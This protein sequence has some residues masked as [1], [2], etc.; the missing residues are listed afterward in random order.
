MDSFQFAA[1][2]VEI[3]GPLR[4]SGE[5]DGIELDAQ[6]FCRDGLTDL[7]VGN[8]FHSLGGHLFEALR[9]RGHSAPPASTM[10]SNS[11]RSSSAAMVLPTS[12]LVTNSTPSADICSR[13]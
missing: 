4:T 10:A 1:G 12:A 13:R 11:M 2:D 3:A 5:H 9:S 7:R 8:E 6:L